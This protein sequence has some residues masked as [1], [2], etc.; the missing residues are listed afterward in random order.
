MAISLNAQ[1]STD[2]EK[3]I[4]YNRLLICSVV[5][6]VEDEPNPK[7]CSAYGCLSAP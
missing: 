5:V 4:V 2:F 1:Y 3:R 6:S 7:Q